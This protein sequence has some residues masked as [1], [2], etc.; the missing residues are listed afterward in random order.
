M[1]RSWPAAF[2]EHVVGLDVAM[3]PAAAV[4]VSQAGRELL[5]NLRAN[6]LIKAMSLAISFDE[7]C[8]TENTP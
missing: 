7:G 6:S 1:I 2:D 5:E 4:H 3:D 8:P